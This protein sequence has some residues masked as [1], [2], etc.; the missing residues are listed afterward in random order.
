MR[1]RELDLRW[2][3]TAALVAMLLAGASR[4]QAQNS[5]LVSIHDANGPVSATSICQTAVG[6]S[7]TFNLKACVNDADPTCAPGVSKKKK[8]HAK[9]HCGA[10]GKLQVGSS[11]GPSCGDFAP[12]KVHTKKNG[13]KPNTCH[14]SI[15]VK[16]KDGRSD[17]QDVDLLCNP[18]STPCPGTGTCSVPQPAS[19]TCEPI[20]NDGQGI[21]G[22]Y[23]LLS[24]QGP[25]LCQ[26]GSSK[27]RFGPCSTDADCGGGTNNCAA[28]SWAT[29]DG[30]VLPCPTGIK[31]VTTVTEDTT[32][33][34]HSVCIACGNEGA[35]C[36][37]IPGCGTTPGQPAPGC[38]RN[39]CCDQPG[40]SLPIFVVPLL[41]GLCSR[42]DQYRCGFG[43]VNTSNPQFGDNEVT[44]V[45][46]TSDPG[47]DCMYGT[48]DDPPAKPCNTGTGGAG[49][50]LKGKVV[51]T[52]GNC[53]ADAPGI[54]YRV[55]VPS[56][57]TTWQ[58]TQSPQGTCNPGSTFD[59]GELIV[60]QL[61]LNAEFTTAGATGSFADLNGDGCALAGA[62]FSNAS[63]AGPFTLGA[64]PASPQPY[65][66][67]TDS[68]GV[69]S[70]ATSAGIALSGNGP[71][72]DLGFT[73]VLTNGPFTRIP[74]QA[75]TCTQTPACPE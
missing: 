3:R 50:D 72:Y 62:G 63:K 25:K 57:S 26:T 41:G 52:V 38:I 49:T 67:H 53:M 5:C 48:A 54:Q 43:V 71:L 2:F 65:D 14:V 32:R 40:F 31:T 47:P 21:S 23:Q 29:A 34:E 12:V 11:T 1:Q 18:S 17:R 58:D 13:K 61:V 4:S 37:G 44:K 60:T 68:M 55:A 35:A 56:L 39:Q 16:T 15:S 6:K 19:F 20:V 28:T 45:G 42:L 74:T 27:N 33:C 46:D 9:G 51:R 59:P 70:I 8:I 64:P 69:A 75:C 24:V 22:T 73:A 10:I 7:C 36:S 30:V 66:G